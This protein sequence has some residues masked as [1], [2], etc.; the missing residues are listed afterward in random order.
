[1]QSVP[2]HASEHFSATSTCPMA[3]QEFKFLS[4]SC[5][6]YLYRNYSEFMQQD[7]RKMRTANSRVWQMWQDYYLHVLSCSSLNNVFWSYYQYSCL[8]NGEIWQK[9]CSN[10][11]TVMFVTP[12]LPSSFLSHCVVLVHRYLSDW[13][14]RTCNLSSTNLYSWRDFSTASNL[15]SHNFAFAIA[16]LRTDSFLAFFPSF[17]PFFLYYGQGKQFKHYTSIKTLSA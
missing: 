3:E 7:G 5:L 1:M 11:I 8:K 12:G 10:K 9:V 13:L 6:L 4:K 15:V 17:F 2:W 14:Q 16:S